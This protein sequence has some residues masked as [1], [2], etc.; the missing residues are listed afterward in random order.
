MAWRNIQGNIAYFIKQY[1][2]MLYK[3]LA[4]HYIYK[5]CISQIKYDTVQFR[6]LLSTNIQY[7]QWYVY[8]ITYM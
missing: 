5:Q 2:D 4:V 1:I 3:I 7:V 6:L 8:I